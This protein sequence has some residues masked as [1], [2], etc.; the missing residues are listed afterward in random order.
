MYDPN[1]NHLTAWRDRYS[2]TCRPLFPSATPAAAHRPE[3]RPMNLLLFLIYIND[4]PNV[5]S[6]QLVTL[7]ADDTNLFM[8]A[9]N[10]SILEKNANDALSKLFTW[11]CANRV[12]INYEKTC[13]MFFHKSNNRINQVNSLKL[14]IK[15][16]CYSSS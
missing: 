11:F 5:V 1:H 14:T 8:S 9:S 4:L 2:K 13:Y 16:F 7:F 6:N 12:S 10:L 3:S 15:Q